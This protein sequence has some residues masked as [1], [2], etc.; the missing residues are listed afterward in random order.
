MGTNY[1]NEPT[2]RYA[3]ISAE[4]C[5]PTNI[6]WTD[7]PWRGRVLYT[8]PDGN[9][10][11]RVTVEPEHRYVGIG[12]M[13]EEGTS[14][15][16]YLWRAAPSTPFPRPRTAG[17][18]EI[19]WSVPDFQDWTLPNSYRQIMLGHFRQDVE[20]RY[21]H[22]YQNAWYPGPNDRVE[23]GTDAALMMNVY[24][25]RSRTAIGGRNNNA[26]KADGQESTS[27]TVT[28]DPGPENEDTAFLM[29]PFNKTA[30]GNGAI[31]CKCDGNPTVV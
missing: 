30:F 29:F 14:E 11:H 13:S 27:S 12:T 26:Y 4:P 22:Q 5:Q 31:A 28:T 9:C 6:L 10:D 16:D 1:D 2:L 3:G 23:P 18:G 17:V 25:P 21:S 8:G 20:D 15:T 19:G 7:E 24:Q